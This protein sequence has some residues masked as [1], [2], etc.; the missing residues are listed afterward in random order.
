MGRKRQK[1]GKPSRLNR[2]YFLLLGIVIVLSV[3]A[4]GLREPGGHFIITS[5]TLDCV[6]SIGASPNLE[7]VETKDKA[8][9]YEISGRAKPTWRWDR[10]MVVDEVKAIAGK[11]KVVIQF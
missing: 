4:F 3:L 9:Y 10:Q 1:A 6:G 2:D 11:N 7:L 8:V 5:E